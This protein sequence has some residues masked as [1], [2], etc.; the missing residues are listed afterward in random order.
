MNNPAPPSSRPTAIPRLTN[1][2]N[3]FLC[4]INQRR[5]MVTAFFFIKVRT[6]ARL[7][8]VCKGHFQTSL[9]H[10]CPGFVTKQVRLVMSIIVMAL[11]WST[12][13]SWP[14]L[15]EIVST[16]WA[17]LMISTSSKQFYS[18]FLHVRSWS[19]NFCRAGKKSSTSSLTRPFI[20][21]S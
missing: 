13:K 10:N 20:T 3:D 2:C 21:S 5:F 19:H 11:C 16:H 9:V 4:I 17:H 1:L 12:S 8:Q 6:T 14:Y 18:W 7:N 15:F